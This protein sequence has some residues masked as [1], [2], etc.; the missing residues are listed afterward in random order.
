MSCSTPDL[1]WDSADAVALGEVH[2]NLVFEDV[3]FGYARAK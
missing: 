2:G 1:L 3:T